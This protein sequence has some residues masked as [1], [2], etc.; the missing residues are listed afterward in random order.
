M[1][2]THIK[3]NVSARIIIIVGEISLVIGSKSS[4]N[5]VRTMEESIGPTIQISVLLR[6]TNPKRKPIKWRTYRR[7]S[8]K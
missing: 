8:M 4:A 3:Q 5:I 1:W 2:K 6:I 7:K